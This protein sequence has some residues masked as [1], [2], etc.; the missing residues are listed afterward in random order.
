MTNNT[1]S[2]N[3]ICINT[4]TERDADK[5]MLRIL[6]GNKHIFPAEKIGKPMIYKLIIK[7]KMISMEVSYR[8][9]SLDGKSRSGILK[10]DEAIYDCLKI[11][12]GAEVILRKESEGEY[13]IVAIHLPS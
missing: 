9:G 4:I 12:K 13:R 6:K 1:T 11:K 7:F 2:S 8:I 5:K 3:T 10:F